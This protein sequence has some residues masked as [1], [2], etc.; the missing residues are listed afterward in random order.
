M[1]D[2][3]EIFWVNGYRYVKHFTNNGGIAS[4]IAVILIILCFTF[5]IIINKIF[6]ERDP[7]G[8]K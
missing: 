5:A 6:K 2:H 7:Y 3:P 4:S 8:K 1:M